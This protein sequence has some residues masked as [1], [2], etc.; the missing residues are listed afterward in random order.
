MN[1]IRRKQYRA[2]FSGQL[3]KPFKLV[4]TESGSKGEREA[5]RLTLYENRYEG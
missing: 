1:P 2:I 5:W 3:F 4:L